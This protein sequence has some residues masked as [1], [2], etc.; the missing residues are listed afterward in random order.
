MKSWNQQVEMLFSFLIYSE[1]KA[2]KDKIK[3]ALLKKGRMHLK[4]QQLI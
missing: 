1:A 4:Q 3:P 2:P